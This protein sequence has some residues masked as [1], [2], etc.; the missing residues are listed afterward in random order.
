MSHRMRATLA[1][2][3]VTTLAAGCTGAMGSGGVTPSATT[4]TAMIGWE[5]RLAVDFRAQSGA[6]GS[7]LE[8]YVTSRHGTPI[9]DVRLLAQGLDANGNVVGQKLTWG[10]TLV[11]ALQRAYFRIPAMPAAATYRVT[12]W[13]YETMEAAGW[14]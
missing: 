4:T 1:L 11:P 12:V 13:S 5:S 8:G 3:A 14:L 10:P 9:M 6:A 7:D 2:L